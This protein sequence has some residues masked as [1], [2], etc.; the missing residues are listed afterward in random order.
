MA[1]AK[2]NLATAAAINLA[3]AHAG[4]DDRRA[5][6]KELFG[7]AKAQFGIPDS[8]KVRAETANAAAPDYLVLKDSKTGQPFEL[9]EDGLWVGADR[10]VDT[11]PAPKRWFFISKD[12]LLDAIKDHVAGEG[13]DWSDDGY[14]D[15]GIMADAVHITDDLVKDGDNFYVRMTEDEL[16]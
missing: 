12:D 5:I 3:R 1:Y 11:T 14:A 7:L 10:P 16:I 8:I 15:A 13:R 2:L 9:A 6:K 4:D